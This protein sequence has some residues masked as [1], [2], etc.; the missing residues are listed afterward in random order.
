MHILQPSNWFVPGTDPGGNFGVACNADRIHHIHF[1]LR[2]EVFAA[3]LND[4]IMGHLFGGGGQGF[5]L[6][7]LPED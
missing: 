7:M 4:L 5:H 2:E 3:L 6:L 1:A